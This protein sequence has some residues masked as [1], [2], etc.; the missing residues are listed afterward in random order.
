MMST[1]KSTIFYGLLIGLS[2]LVMGMV[3]A[4]RLDLAPASFALN[5]PETNSAPITGPLDATTFRTIADQASPSVVSLITV[6]E[7]EAREGLFFGFPFG[8]EMGPDAAPEV[9]EGAGSGFIID[10]E[11]Y[12]LTNNHVVADASRIE[13]FLKGM[14]GPTGLPATVVGRD[15]L[16]DSALI[17]LDSLPRQ[18]LMPAKFGDSS[19]IAPGDWVMAIGNPFRLSHTVTVGVVSAVGRPQ[20][21]A[22]PG[23]SEDMIQTDAAINQGNSGGPLLNLRGEVVGINT[24]IISNGNA[25]SGIAGNIGIGFAVPIN[26]V[27]DVLPQLRTGKVVRGRIGVGIAPTIITEE[28]AADL[29]LSGPSGAI[30]AS[31]EANGPAD[32]AGLRVADVIT[33]FNGQPVANNDA[34]VSMVTRTTPGTTIPVKVVRNRET[35]TLNVTV[36]ELNLQEERRISMTDPAPGQS[37]EPTETEFG[38]SVQELT[39]A[40]ARELNFPGNRR[41]AVIASVEP[42]G[43]A[44]RAGLQRGDVIVRINNTAVASVAD[45]TEALAAI[46]AGRTARVVVWRN[47]QEVLFLVR[48]R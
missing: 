13:V 14:T 16:T 26:T 32:R 47:G 24:M 45:A 33:E 37:A 6:T 18:P 11:G 46:A 20:T 35:L 25:L 36:G 44:Q 7:R 28:D 12:I 27:R 48:A 1:R 8:R 43:P 39:P 4:S 34:L 38:M 10:A 5:V 29:G 40:I 42:A 21:L 17:K 19:Q 3:I 30:V 31:V 15:E 22:V 23:R 9:A 41:G 2:C